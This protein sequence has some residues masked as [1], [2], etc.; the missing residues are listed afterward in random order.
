M[1]K[2]PVVLGYDSTFFD[3][4]AATPV[5]EGFELG[6]PARQSQVRQFANHRKF[7]DA[8][9]GRRRETADQLKVPLA[10]RGLTDAMTFVDEFH[11]DANG[12]L[13]LADAVGDALAPMLQATREPA[14]AE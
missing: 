5:E 1:Y 6:K 7:G 9:Y 11:C 10:G 3:K 13:L 14:N 12:M 8:F 2:V 4:A